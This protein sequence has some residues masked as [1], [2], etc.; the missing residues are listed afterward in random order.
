MKEVSKDEKIILLFSGGWESSVL[1]FIARE[2]GYKVHCIIV[3]YGQ[4]HIEEVEYA[5]SMCEE[6]G[7]GYTMVEMQIP[8]K[9]ALTN[10]LG[11]PYEKVS[12]WYVPGRNLMLVSAAAAIAESEGVETIW[13]GAS[14]TDRENNFPDCSQEWVH[15]INKVLAEGTSRKVRVLAP[16]LGFTKKMVIEMGNY[17][18]INEEEVF[19]GYGEK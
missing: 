7:F 11:T 1:L 8:T 12:P 3:D 17:F 18:D 14:Y 2:L 6:K 16:L 4:E 9:S 19:S 15:A 10:P 13:I 5:K